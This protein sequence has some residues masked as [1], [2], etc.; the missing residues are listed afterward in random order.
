MRRAARAGAMRALLVA[1]ML[2]LASGCLGGSAPPA[3]TPS[4][5][6]PSVEPTPSPPTGEPTPPAPTEE[7]PAPMPPK[8]IADQSFDFNTEGDATGQSVK[9][10]PTDAV[11]DGYGNVT[12][13]VTIVRATAAP[14]TL[15]VTGA[16][17]T[18]S[19]RVVASNGT[20]VAF[21]RD[22][23]ALSK[24]VPGI[25][26]AWRVEYG[27]AGTMRATVVITAFP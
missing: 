1:A 16:V 27:G 6:T 8:V 13:N 18:P 10:K 19:V 5:G 24:S 4:P 25:A 7:P 26:G 22:E 20:E 12:V 2:L 23:G 9:T 15:P 17:N 11:P 14:A 3:P 21:Q